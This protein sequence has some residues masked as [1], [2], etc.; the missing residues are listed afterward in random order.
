MARIKPTPVIIADLKQTEGALAEIAAIERE[1][2]AIESEMQET[3]DNA[4]TL[5]KQKSSALSDRKKVL[6]SAV[7][8]YATL[9]RKELFAKTK[10]LDLGIG[11]I[12]FRLSTKITQIKGVPVKMTLEKL[13]QFG[14][15]EA[16]RIKEDLNKEVASDWPD[17][18]LQ[19]VGL[20]RQ[21]ED[22]FFIEINKDK[23]EK[24]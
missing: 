18:R 15:L 21:T 9:N 3:I 24:A 7:S 6:E 23:V 20:Q 10:S 22:A 13:H 8:V 2:L 16:I 5:A 4:K 12:G 14:L 17:E 19:L 11:V 1:L